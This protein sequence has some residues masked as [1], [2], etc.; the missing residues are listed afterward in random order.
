MKHYFE[1]LG[2]TKAVYTKNKMILEKQGRLNKNEMPPLSFYKD[3]KH[4]NH[5]YYMENRDIIDKI[6]DSLYSFITR[7]GIDETT[8]EAA[9]ANQNENN[10]LVDGRGRIELD[11]SSFFYDIIKEEWGR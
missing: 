2:E 9:K 4:P 3:A 7:G 10:R 5:D 1:S 11:N 8:Q 6:K